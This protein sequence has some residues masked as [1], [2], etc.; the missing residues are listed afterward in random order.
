MWMN[1]ILIKGLFPFI[2]LL[3]AFIPAFA[4]TVSITTIATGP[5]GNGSTITV[6]FTI[7][8]ASGCIA[9]DNTYS[10]FLCN[11]AGVPIS[12]T[13]VATIASFY[14]TF[15]N[16]KVPAGTPAGTYTF[17][18][19]T[20]D[21]VTTSA[22]SNTFT[23]NTAAGGTA[24]ATC[25]STEIT[26]PTYPEVF[27]ACSGSN[28][29]P[30]TFT[31][32]SS[33]GSTTTA[34][35]TN[36]ITHA[37]EA[38]NVSLNPS[39]TF[40]ANAGNYTVTVKSVTAG[41]VVSTYSY[42]LINNVVNT[43]LGTT[44]NSSACL[45][46]GV[47][48]LTYNVDVSS[49]TGIQ[50][51]YPGNLYTISWGD[52]TPNS[53]FT[54]CQLEALNGQIMHPYTKASCSY[55]APTSAN[56]FAVN[57]YTQN[58]YCGNIGTVPSD[59]AKIYNVPI[60]SFTGAAAS[61]SSGPVTF[62]NTSQPGPDPNASTST[63]SNNPNSLYNWSVDG[64]VVATGY[65]LT[66]NF[67]T[68]LT[69]GTHTILLHLVNPVNGNGC[70]PG[71]A[72]QTICIQDPPKP[73][74][75]L[76]PRNICVGDGPI[77]PV[78]TS[79]IDAICNI[80]N[81][82][83]WKV[84]PSTGVTFNPASPAPSI[85]FTVPGIYAVSMSVTTAS[86][87]TVSAPTIDTVVVNAPP[88]ATLSSDYSLCGDN[89]TLKFDS[90]TTSKT[91]TLL[92]GTSQQQANTYTWTVTGGA[93]SYAPGYTA[94]SKYPHIIFKDYATYTITV[95]QQNNCGSVTSA[96]QHITFEEAPTVIAGND[97]TICAG[98]TANLH[99]VITGPG[100]SSYKWIGGSGTFTPSVDSL[101]TTYLP[102][103]T[104]VAAG[105]VTLGLQAT[106]SVATPCNL[107]TSSLTI[108]ITSIGTITSGLVKA[109][110]SNQRLNYQPT[111]SN[112]SSTFTWTATLVSG[113][114]SGFAT[115]GSGINI[116][117]SLINTDPTASINAVIAYTITPVSATGCPGTPSTL[118]VTVTPL[119]LLTAM[120]T[121]PV[122]CSNQPAN[123][124]LSTKLA[125]TTYLWTST[126]S[127][128]VSGN[129][130][131]TTPINTTAIQD[132]LI[133]NGTAPATVT[134]VITPI[135]TNGCYG[136]PV[137]SVINVEPLPVTAYAGPDTT[138][139]SVT[140]T[141]PLTGNSPGFGH[142]KW[143]VVHGTGITFANDT[144]P[145]TTVSGMTG[146]NTYQ[147]QWTITTAPGCQSES[148]VTIVVNLPT[149]PGTT[150]TTGPTTVCANAN[151]GQINLT[152][153]VGKI[154]K[155]QKS[156]D[157]GTT[158]QPVIPLDTLSSLLYKDLTQTTQFQALVQN[159]NCDILASTITIITVNQPA[160]TADAGPDT[161]LC[162]AS[163][164]TLMG[165]NPGTNLAVWHQISG[166][167]VIF[168]DST[169]YQTTISNLQGGNIYTFTWIIKG[170]SPC[171]NS[172]SQV[173]ITV[174]SDVVANFKASTTNAC[175]SQLITFTNLSTNPTGASFL[176]NFGDG[177]TSTALNPQHQF[178]QTLSG[179]DTT[180]IVSLS[181]INNCTQR[182]PVYDTITIRSDKPVASILPQQTTGCTPFTVTVV[183]T[184]PGNNISY[185]F[186]L[187]NGTT[188]IQEIDKT[189]K[190]N[191]V[192]D[193]LTVYTQ[194]QYTVYMVA[195]GQCGTV[196][197]SN[198]IPIQIAPPT[199][200][201]QMYILNGISMGC[202]PLS[203]VFVNNSSGGSTFHYNIYDANGN[204]VS[205]PVAG[206]ANFP[207]IFTTSGTY[208]VSITAANSC[209]PAGLESAKIEVDVYPIPQPA[210]VAT[211]DCSGL[212]TFSNNTTQNGSTPPGSLSYKWDFGDGSNPEYTFNP[213]PH[214]FNYKKSPFVVKLIA[215]NL[216]S[217]CNDSTSQTVNV[218]IP[219]IAQ[220][221]ERPDSIIKVPNY[222]FSF[223]DESSG[224]PVSW[225]WTLGDGATSTIQFPEHT[226]ADTGYYQVTLITTS[227]EGCTSTVTHIVDITGT[228][229]QLFMPNA[230]MPAGSNPDLRTF[231]AKGSGMKTWTMQ[232]FNHYGQLLWETTKL[233]SN[234]APVDGWDGTYKGL[235]M[236]QGA[237][238]W[239]ISATFID[240]SNWKGMSY[241][242]SLPKRTGTVN[243]IR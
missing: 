15:F 95:M 40:T 149:V 231:M 55:T 131:Q 38:N 45:V 50:Y 162:G 221:S 8:D 110:C 126:T 23:I 21:P 28:G 230:F 68:T 7:N 192:F 25:P 78:N 63:C 3:F 57:L 49:L 35:F 176:W 235:L 24:A 242:N 48:E 239:Q 62:I 196:D 51:N 210:F 29:M 208:F 133:N 148:A 212:E 98:T 103:P 183:N 119:P 197:T 13:P 16:Y 229:G 150:G 60:T 170:A 159:N 128:S 238:I 80:N 158:W 12:A 201:P 211:T 219:F 135:S 233:D 178:L 82:Y 96:P 85:Q 108:T 226:Y 44:G 147:F 117:D 94:N 142:G 167:P 155:W 232:I 102:S 204:I 206:L 22:V 234:G 241:D 104:E 200:T 214:R 222:H 89:L 168:A 207:Y 10:L 157:N 137:T 53:V 71:D 65:H 116:T 37:V 121:S 172:Q 92:T 120:P 4:Q 124:Q 91:Y 30:Y 182:P 2:L 74:F 18:I 218:G 86:C 160:P 32:A 33:A 20:S 66:Q 59:V 140:N 139:C 166:P 52:G 213:N 205:Q 223:I 5:Y 93:Y 115:T 169:N 107:I 47:A 76:A 132:L 181:V 9:Q 243:L 26:N 215:T 81:T 129:S 14:G 106:T 43:A 42:Q 54:L 31:N 56:A 99:G 227:K 193:P 144:I 173:N 111:A 224:S 112:A 72:T 1:K 11:A 195:T 125:G 41:G 228:P 67:T 88:V 240:G 146:G 122:I 39:Y 184:S 165:N 90:L 83:T 58:P 61:C 188:L 77:T 97:T 34:T 73:S 198:I 189:D 154:L 190:S 187:Y 209:T 105:H 27:G 17:L 138:L 123:I 202:T 203:V 177:S 113:M 46:G 143:T 70:L 134:Y 216:V 118:N 87:G 101:T 69:R 171:S 191:A 174:N 136:T 153:E 151:S 194:K 220:F 152:G 127:A 19:K 100:V 180:Y 185:K 179:K 79:I 64:V 84:N 163:T 186:Y 75:T 164:Y 145:N 236:Q 156:I 175:G 130:N 36:Q 114:A 109:I 141:Y 237:Y 225:A 199:V 161:T 217:G 6:P